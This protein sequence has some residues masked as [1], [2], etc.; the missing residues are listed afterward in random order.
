[1]SESEEFWEVRKILGFARRILMSELS[2][3]QVTQ[4]LQDWNLGDEEALPKLVPLLYDEL[5]RIAHFYMRGEKPEHTLRTTALIN[6]TYLRL[7]QIHR[8]R[9]KDRNHFLAVSSRLM[10]RILVD[11]ARARGAEKRGGDI[12]PIPLQD[13]LVGQC[14]LKL[15]LIALDHTLEA[16]A[17]LDPRKAKVVELRFFGG[18]DVRRTASVLNI[19]PAT[20]MRDWDFAKAWIFQRLRKD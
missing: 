9:W 15:D 14:D 8:I 18:L 20:V 2:G 3:E 16:L 1:M 4:I 12:A 7:A 5:H 6:E 17:E 19:S 11:F 13:D 10:R